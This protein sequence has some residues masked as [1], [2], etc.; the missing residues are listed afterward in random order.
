[1]GICKGNLVGHG[2]AVL[3]MDVGHVDADVDP[4]AIYSGMEGTD[5]DKVLVATAGA[6]HFVKV[7]LRSRR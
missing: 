1:M 6:D 4:A 2:S 7:M 3:C 5:L